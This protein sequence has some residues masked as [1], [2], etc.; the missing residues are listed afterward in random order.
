[1]TTASGLLLEIGADPSYKGTRVLEWC[2]AQSAGSPDI[3][4]SVVKTLY[5]M[6]AEHFCTSAKCIERNIRTTLIKM[7]D[8]EKWPERLSKFEKAH[9]C[10]GLFSADDYQTPKR[11]ITR[12][13][14]ILDKE[15]RS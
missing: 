6:A 1:M 14:Y 8:A 2:I 11:F 10:E 15:A 4:D 7:E 12:M 13:A 3:A 5:P 9:K